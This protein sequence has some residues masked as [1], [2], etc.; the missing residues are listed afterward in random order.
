MRFLVDAQLPPALASW[1]QWKGHEASHVADAGLTNANDPAIWAH[2]V[3]LAAVLITKDEDFLTLRAAR[4]G[5]CAVVWLRI[6]NAT[7]HALLAWL[8]PRFA[9]VLAALE[10][11]ETVV[12]VR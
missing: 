3:Q 1:L 4:P 6:G 12:E 5:D 9:R 7:N 11:G 2:A 8:S 10:A